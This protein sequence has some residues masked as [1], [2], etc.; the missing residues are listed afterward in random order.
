MAKTKNI[1]IVIINIV[2]II[3]KRIGGKDAAMLGDLTLEP[4]K[5]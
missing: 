4:G 2:I 5:L 3:K 1:Y